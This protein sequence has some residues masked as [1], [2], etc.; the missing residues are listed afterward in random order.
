MLKGK[1]ISL[2]LTV[3]FKICAGFGMKTA[4]NFLSELK[5]YIDV[6]KHVYGKRN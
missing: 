3:Y 4:R 2:F 1:K 5:V 6:G